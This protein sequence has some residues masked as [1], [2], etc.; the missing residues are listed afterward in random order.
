V[1]PASG[2]ALKRLVVGGST[3]SLATISL[4]SKALTE[5]LETLKA[6][7]DVAFS[8]NISADAA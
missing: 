1:N 7:K 5:R 2:K 4:V 3:P 6:Q 8:T